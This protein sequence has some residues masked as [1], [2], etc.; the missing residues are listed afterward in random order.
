MEIFLC[1]N[2]SIE[3]C[4]NLRPAA[5]REF[6]VDKNLSDKVFE[7]IHS[8]AVAENRPWRRVPAE[9]LAEMAGTSEYGGI[10]AR[11]ERPEP[12]QV[13]PA[14]LEEWFESGER[15]LFV[16]KISDEK[17]L[18]SIMRV[19]AICGITRVVADEKTTIPAL[20]RS[21]VWNLSEGALEFL[22]I[23]KTESMTGMLRKASA[24][25]F[26][27]GLVRE[28]GRKIDY[29]KPPVFPGKTVALLLSGDANGVPAEL[30]SRCGHLF[31]ISEKADFPVKFKVDEICAFTL[32]WLCSAKS[33]RSGTGFLSRKKS[34]GAA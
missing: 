8:A 11:T 29:D 13:H 14:M 5:V 17:S 10:V 19:A 18:A 34:K 3:A 9:E 21:R 28:G 22:K 6:F 27:V 23:Y 1:G 24:R 2:A 26:V 16:E 4:L 7:K 20:V 33:V 12:G 32:P 31:H 15:P 25:F 30:I